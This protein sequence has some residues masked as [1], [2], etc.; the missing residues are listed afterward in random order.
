MREAATRSRWPRY[1]SD[2]GRGRDVKTGSHENHFRA[3]F[4]TPFL[5]SDLGTFFDLAWK[6]DPR[7]SPGKLSKLYRIYTWDQIQAR[8][9]VQVL[10]RKVVPDLIAEMVLVGTK[11]EV[12]NGGQ[13]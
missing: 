3:Q 9:L 11:C 5:G 6:L 2:L 13:S 10:A 7:L 4:W 12:E 8:K 1:R